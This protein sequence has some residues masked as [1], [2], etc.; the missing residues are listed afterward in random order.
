MRAQ[1]SVGRG[2]WSLTWFKVP[3]EAV[4]RVGDSFGF[5]GDGPTSKVR[6]VSWTPFYVYV[7]LDEGPMTFEA[8]REERAAW[9]EA[10]TRAQLP[11]P[12]CDPSAEECA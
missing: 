5:D 6:R 12:D 1:I 10:A 11:P 2:G 4:P 8:W 7:Y 9:I 3:L